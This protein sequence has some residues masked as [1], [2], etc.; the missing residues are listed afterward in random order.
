MKYMREKQRFYIR[1]QIYMITLMALGV[2][3]LLFAHNNS[4]LVTPY[5]ILYIGGCIA[6]LHY[7]RQ[8][9]R[10]VLNIIVKYWQQNKNILIIEI[11]RIQSRFAQIVVCGLMC[12][13]IT[14]S[15]TGAT[16]VYC[17]DEYAFA[18]FLCLLASWLL[19]RCQ[20]GK[21]IGCFCVI[22]ALSIYQAY[23]IVAIA[24]CYLVAIVDFLLG[25]KTQVIIKQGIEGLALLLCS[26]MAYFGIW[27]VCCQALQ[28]EKN[29]L[30]E[31]VLSSGLKGIA[32]LVLQ[33]GKEYLNYLTQDS[34]SLFGVLLPAVHICLIVLCIIKMVEWMRDNRATYTEKLI[35]EL[36]VCVAPFVFNAAS[37]LFVGTASYLTHF[38]R[39][40]IYFWGSI[41]K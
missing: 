36:L 28:V 20:H 9:I 35:L 8:E 19:C 1:E 6:V 33:S 30:N 18:L 22:V 11:L 17:L 40:F 7:R 32:L 21:L 39:S 34:G 4:R 29:R 37:I 25:K 41:V 14:L 13:N 38:T 16:Y 26:F 10:W 5:W 31:T 27:T 15:L 2:L 3:G 12:S 24:C 23:F